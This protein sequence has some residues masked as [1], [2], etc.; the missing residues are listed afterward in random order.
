MGFQAI[1]LRIGDDATTVTRLPGFCPSRFAQQY[2]QISGTLR[3]DIELLRLDNPL[4]APAA[5]F[6]GGQRQSPPFALVS[7]LSPEMCALVA[8]PASSPTG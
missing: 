4:I 8:M 7:M 5:V 2:Q 3:K 1:P 6:D